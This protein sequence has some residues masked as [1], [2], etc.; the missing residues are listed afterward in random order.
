[1]LVYSF[2]SK[3]NPNPNPNPSFKKDIYS[4]AVSSPLAR[5]QNPRELLPNVYVHTTMKTPVL[6]RSRKLSIVGPG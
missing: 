2:V 4:Y 1:M 5:D 6:V 3:C